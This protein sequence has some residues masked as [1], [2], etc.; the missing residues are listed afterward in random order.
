MQTK[1]QDNVVQVWTFMIR[2]LCTICRKC[3]DFMSLFFFFFFTLYILMKAKNW[4]VYI[5]ELVIG[6]L[7]QLL[8]LKLCNL[9]LF[10]FLFD[11]FVK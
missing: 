3:L 2:L 9:F 8:Y 1:Q 4:F 6:K 5:I 7:H 11:K 10:F